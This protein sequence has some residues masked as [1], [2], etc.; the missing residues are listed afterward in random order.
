M[1]RLNKT[2]TE[3]QARFMIDQTLLD[4]INRMTAGTY[5]LSYGQL[6]TRAIDLLEPGHPDYEPVGRLEHVFPTSLLDPIH[7][8]KLDSFCG[9]G[10]RRST[11]MRNAL[12]RLMA[13]YDQP[14]QPKKEVEHITIH[15]EEQ[16]A[17]IQS[18]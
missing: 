11:V 4:F 5:G 1:P 17:T 16:P 12:A 13:V 3:G 18:T 15:E 14:A 10:Q 9:D 8:A 6:L 7:A 2:K